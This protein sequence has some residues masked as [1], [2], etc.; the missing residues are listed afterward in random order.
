MSRYA[1]LIEFDG[2]RYHGWQIQNG[3]PTVQESLEKAAYQ[4]TGEQVRVVGAG[5]T[6]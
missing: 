1:L 3:V 4:L 5:R 6:D 2:T